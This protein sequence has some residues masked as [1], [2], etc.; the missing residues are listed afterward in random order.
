[1]YQILA[2]DH[3]FDFS[4]ISIR[5]NRKNRRMNVGVS[6]STWFVR[7]LWMEL[8]QSGSLHIRNL[9]EAMDLLFP[10]WNKA[11]AS[12]DERIK[13]I[14]GANNAKLEYLVKERDLSQANVTAGNSKWLTAEQTA[15]ILVCSNEERQVAKGIYEAFKN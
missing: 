6:P 9:R 8:E 5:M 10:I 3:S 11:M 4:K 15:S 13:F 2:I 1:M 14:R 12:D 7:V